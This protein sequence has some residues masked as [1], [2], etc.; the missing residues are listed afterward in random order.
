MID[1]F[2]CIIISSNNF[3]LH[4]HYLFIIQ[5]YYKKNA[6]TK[7]ARNL[8][9]YVLAKTLLENTFIH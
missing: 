5:K 8:K 6:T 9:I 2:K 7:R 1:V 4:Q 3:F